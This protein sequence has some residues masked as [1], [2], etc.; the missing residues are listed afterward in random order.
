METRTTIIDA[1]DAYFDYKAKNAPYEMDANATF[2]DIKR[3]VDNDGTVGKRHL[4]KIAGRC[5]I[6]ERRFT[7]KGNVA[8]TSYLHILKV[9]NF[10]D[11]KVIEHWREQ[12]GGNFKQI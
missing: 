12:K 4:L 9:N 3:H 5:V 6:A 2:E 7:W 1:F 8:R 11:Y 10:T